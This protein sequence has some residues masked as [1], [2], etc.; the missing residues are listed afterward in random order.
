MAYGSYSGNDY[1]ISSQ[2]HKYTSVIQFGKKWT[3]NFSSS[4]GL[5]MLTNFGDFTPVP[6]AHLI[7]S[8]KPWVFDFLIPIDV[9]IRYLASDKWYIL[10]QHKIGGRSYN[11]E[12]TDMALNYDF[13]ELIL[14]T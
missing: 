11:Y 12:P 3:P 14:K 5:L 9:N 2:N 7:Y 1:S 8:R 4:L 6:L 13:N 10:L